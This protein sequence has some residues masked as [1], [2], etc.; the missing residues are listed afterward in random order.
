MKEVEDYE[1]Q[2]D[3]EVVEYDEVKEMEHKTN[4]HYNLR[5]SV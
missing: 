3:N 4:P 1:V 5:S 2:E